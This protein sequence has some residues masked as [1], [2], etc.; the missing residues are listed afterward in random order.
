VAWGSESNSS[1]RPAWSG[2][3]SRVSRGICWLNLGVEAAVAVT[4]EMVDGILHVTLDEPGRGNSFGLENAKALAT[5]L[6]KQDPMRIRGLIFTA[7]GRLFCAGGN[8]A[9][10]ARMR[11]AAQGRVTN[12]E[13]T[14]IL[15]RLREWP[16]PTVCLVNGDC[17][18]GGVELLSA[19]DKVF[20]VPEAMFGLWQR[21][22]GLSF[23]WGGGSRLQERLGIFRTRQLALEAKTF[24]V[25]EARLFGLVDEIC[26]HSQ[27]EARAREW[28][29]A[30][31]KLPQAPVEGVKNFTAGR[32]RTIFERLWWNDEHRRILKSRLRSR[33]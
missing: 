15:K 6:K 13:I 30:Q 8:L 2:S 4:S 7:R 10:Y 24:S 19:F 16:A 17:F 14:K 18:G 31:A 11:T 21:R 32:E 26:F 33:L 22:V 12:R 1:A 25:Y 23:G 3:D 9:D 29:A 5:V 28:L 20:A 27:M